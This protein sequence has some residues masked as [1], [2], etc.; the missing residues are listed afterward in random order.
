MPAHGC[1]RAVPCH[2]L[3]LRPA[4]PRPSRA[5]DQTAPRPGQTSRPPCPTWPLACR[6]LPDRARPR[7]T[8]ATPP[9]LA[10]PSLYKTAANLRLKSTITWPEITDT[11]QPPGL[12]DDLAECR[13][14]DI[15]G[16]KT[17]ISNPA[18]QPLVKAGLLE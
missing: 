5:P 15:S 7:Q 18:C 14:I 8:A 4:R 2:A 16:T 6:A 3:G 9:R 12:A 1:G 17:V 10:V 13:Q 11:D